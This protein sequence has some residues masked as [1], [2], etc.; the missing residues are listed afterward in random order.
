M[1]YGLRSR[2]RL[3]VITF[4]QTVYHSYTGERGD[5]LNGRERIISAGST[6]FLLPPFLFDLVSPLQEQQREP[7]RSGRGSETRGGER[8]ARKPG[9]LIDRFFR[10]IARK[11]EQPEEE[12]RRRGT[13]SVVPFEH[14]EKFL[15]F[16]ILSRTRCPAPRVRTLLPPLPSPPL[17]PLDTR[18]RT[19]R[20]EKTE[21]KIAGE[22]SETEKRME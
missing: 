20:G 22:V 12:A 6:D 5:T 16:E 19:P 8:G 14:P 1:I 10:I 4:R 3:L 7:G 21:T 11:T 17:S 13:W 9:T 2:E 18:A 15:S